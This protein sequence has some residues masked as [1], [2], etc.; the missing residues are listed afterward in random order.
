MRIINPTYICFQSTLDT[1]LKDS[2]ASLH[3][4]NA[5]PCPVRISNKLIDVPVH[6]AHVSEMYI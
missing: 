2:Q 6:V 1:P 3:F 4:I 5:A